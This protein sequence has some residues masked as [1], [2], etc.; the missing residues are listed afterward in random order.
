MFKTYEQLFLVF[1]G[2]CRGGALLF[3]GVEDELVVCKGEWYREG[4]GGV[5]GC[6]NWWFI[7]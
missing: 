3:V 7:S 2:K 4:V 6:V 1:E 5:L